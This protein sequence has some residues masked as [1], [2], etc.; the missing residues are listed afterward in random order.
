MQAYM[1]VHF[2]K[3]SLNSMYMKANVCAMSKCQMSHDLLRTRL[4]TSND[5]Q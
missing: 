5:P 3:N 4:S 2:L 1:R